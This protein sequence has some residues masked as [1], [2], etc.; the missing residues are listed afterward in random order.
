MISKET[1]TFVMRALIAGFLFA[2]VLQPRS[3][4]EA[5]GQTAAAQDSGWLMATGNLAG[6]G[7]VC[8]VFDT[9]TQHLGAYTMRGMQFK[10]EAMRF[11][12][13][14]FRLVQQGEQKPSVKEI[15][16]EVEKNKKP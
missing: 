6:A 11:C 8:F 7:T 15:K 9:K 2:L 5:R 1:L 12:E 10:F 14:D 4:P 3:M 13:Y 16:D